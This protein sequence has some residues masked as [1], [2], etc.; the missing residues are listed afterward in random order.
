MTGMQAVLSD[1]RWKTK[2]DIISE[3]EKSGK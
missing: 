1:A 2:H 3:I